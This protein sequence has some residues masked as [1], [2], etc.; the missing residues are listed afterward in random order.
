MKPLNQM[1]SSNRYARL[2]CKRPVFNCNSRIGNINKRR[3]SLLWWNSK[4]SNQ[5]VITA[6]HCIYGNKNNSFETRSTD[7]DADVQNDTFNRSPR[8]GNK[9]KQI[10]RNVLLY[11][12]KLVVPGA[13]VGI[14]TRHGRPYCGGSL[15]NNRYVLTAGHCVYK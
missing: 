4:I 7:D 6:A 12:L 5:Y 9:F 11:L 2:N 3:I 13:A 10:I 14:T 8:F 1:K 15:L